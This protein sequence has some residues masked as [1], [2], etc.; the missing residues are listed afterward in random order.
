MSSCPAGLAAAVPVAPV[1]PFVNSDGPLVRPPSEF[2]GI[3]L[4]GTSSIGKLIT[5]KQELDAAT[6]RAR[7]RPSWGRSGTRLVPFDAIATNATRY[8]RHL[9]D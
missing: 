1:L 5:Q 9:L 2:R 8:G 4:E 6:H 3:R 7:T